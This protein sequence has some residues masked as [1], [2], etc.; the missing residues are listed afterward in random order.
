MTVA[1]A[2]ANGGIG[3]LETTA[4]R[5]DSIHTVIRKLESTEQL[6]ICYEAGPDGSVLYR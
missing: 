6:R 1:F 3:S 4:N 2:E 5:S